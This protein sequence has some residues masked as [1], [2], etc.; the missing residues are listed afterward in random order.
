MYSPT[1]PQ[2]STHLPDRLSDS[3]FLRRHDA[4]R[5]EMGKQELD[6]IVVFGTFQGWQNV[7]YLSNHWDL[8]S[9]YLLLFASH[10]PVLVTGVYPHL[11]SVKDNSIVRDIRFGGTRSVD[12]ITELLKDRGMP[13]RRVGLIEPD[14]YRL[15]GI[16]YRDLTRLMELNPATH[17][18]NCTAMLEEVRRKKSPEEIALLRQCAALTDHCLSRTIDAVRPGITEKD[19]AHE[20]ASSPGET[21]AVLIGSTSMA[22]PH[23]PAPAIRPT[24]REL[25]LGDVV[26]IELSKGGAGYAGQVHGMITL[27]AATDRYVEMAKLAQDAYRSILAALH[28][29]CTPQK[30]ADAALMITRAG[31]TITNPLIHGFGMGI[32][33]GLHV[34]MPGAG[35]YWP[36]ADFTFP[37]SATVTIEPNPCN[38]E[39]TMGTTAGGLVL[40]TNDGCE[41]M[42]KLADLEMVQKLA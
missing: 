35:P 5:L 6:G 42:Q 13:G 25:R 37:Q 41:P 7:F 19:L 2:R 29:G 26:M 18:S 34:G 1:T 31:Y 17:F 22:D 21:V 9:C 12:L 10:D 33:P 8:V 4:V 36:P 28:P 16:P 39:M 32:E 3:E 14:S 20:I 24:S 30:A 40:I 38:R 23:L 27:G 15:P 11:A